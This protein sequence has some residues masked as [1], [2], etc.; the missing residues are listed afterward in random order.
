MLKYYL[1]K[2]KEN[3]WKMEIFWKFLMFRKFWLRDTA[4]LLNIQQE[5]KWLFE[6][7]VLDQLCEVWVKIYK[8]LISN[9]ED[10]SGAYFKLHMLCWNCWDNPALRMC[11]CC[12]FDNRVWNINGKISKQI[13]NIREST[14][15]RRNVPGVQ[16][17][18]IVAH[19]T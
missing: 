5:K 16:I 4:Y 12:L 10:L 18:K 7:M 6:L 15:W 2:I 14:A 3:A 8:Y 17:T 1:C 11:L 13:F 19:R 9:L